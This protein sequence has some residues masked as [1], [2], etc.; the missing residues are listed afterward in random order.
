MLRHAIAHAESTRCCERDPGV[1]GARSA[2][3]HA[4]GTEAVAHRDECIARGGRTAACNGTGS[5]QHRGIA[6]GL[7]QP[8]YGEPRPLATGSGTPSRA[9]RASAAMVAILVALR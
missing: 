5:A 3:S 9:D 2:T 4:A 7:S 6:F 1:G 8:D